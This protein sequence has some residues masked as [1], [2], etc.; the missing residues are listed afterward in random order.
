VIGAQVGPR[1]APRVP[2][3]R[4]RQLFGLVLLYAA[5]NMAWKALR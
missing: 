5:A 2:T 3:R 1:L 4:L